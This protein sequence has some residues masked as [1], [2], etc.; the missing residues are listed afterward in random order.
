MLGYK[1]VTGELYSV[2]KELSRRIQ[3]I[4][5]EYVSPLYGPL[6][7]FD[8]VDSARRFL[9]DLVADEDYRIYK[10]DYIPSVYS[11]L[12]YEDDG[13][14]YYKMIVPEGTRF[15]SGVKLLHLTEI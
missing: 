8:T 15:A 10:C 12:W 7:V 11:Y 5:N 14:T 1:V 3:Y 13:Q 9:D 4:E 2:G 6:A